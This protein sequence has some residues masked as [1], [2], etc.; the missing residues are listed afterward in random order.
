ME[1]LQSALDEIE[2]E[3]ELLTNP[4]KWERTSYSNGKWTYTKRPISDE[5]KAD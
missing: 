1:M 2:E 3:I 4:R 5:E